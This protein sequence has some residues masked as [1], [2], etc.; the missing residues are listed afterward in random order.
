MGAEEDAGKV[1]EVYRARTKKLGSKAAVGRQLGE[2]EQ[3]AYDLDRNDDGMRT[4][5][6]LLVLELMG[7]PLP[8]EVYHEA[9]FS[10]DTDPAAILGYAREAQRLP[11]DPFVEWLKPQL[12]ALA[13]AGPTA[14][15]LEAPSLVP[16]IR[17]LDRLRRRDRPLA[18]ERLQMQIAFALER[19]G[20]SRPR[21]AL[22]ELAIALGVFAVVQR[23]IG[24]RDDALDL[25]VLARPLAVAA[26][27]P[28]VE[29]EWYQKAAYLL[30]DLSRCSRADEFILRAHM[31]YDQAGA[32]IER[33]RCQVDRAYIYYHL[34]K[35][36]VSM[37]MLEDVLPRLFPADTEY[38]HS[39]HQVLALNFYSLGD[40][41]AARDQ[42]DLAI[43]LVGD[44]Y[45]AK[46]YTLTSRGELLAK[47]GELEAGLA[48]Y[49]EAL[50]LLAKVTGAGEVAEA[51][52]A[53]A[54]LL[55]EEEERRPELL[56]LA[57]DL[58]GWMQSLDGNLK[59]RAAIEDFQALIPLDQL[60]QQ[61]FAEILRLVTEAKNPL[62]ER[63]TKA[64]ESSRPAGRQ[65]RAPVRRRPGSG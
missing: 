25:L 40:E 51:G 34:K 21:P 55:L 57:A 58:S 54:R 36:S 1:R 60:D 38:R 26:S 41:R 53:Y 17:R 42:L 48:C 47:S 13:A 62:R 43:A 7:C 20:A 49:R 18:Q 10:V 8:P 63:K 31:L 3:Y 52:M 9:L 16:E 11:P 65:G 15:Q 29:A 12:A 59:L 23:L 46:A 6:L 4:G 19:L 61:T 27:D 33:L 50:P 35:Y 39:A 5:D 24:R 44:D 28:K 32:E 22:G 37:K 14:G 45:F 64:K 2:G 56:A 30:V